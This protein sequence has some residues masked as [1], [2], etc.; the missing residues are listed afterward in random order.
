MSLR[1][2]IAQRSLHA[3]AQLRRAGEVDLERDRRI[4]LDAESTLPLAAG[5]TETSVEIAGVPVRRYSVGDSSNGVVLFLHGGAYVVGGSRVARTYSRLALEGTDII[6]VDYRLAPENPYPAGL[7]DA[8]AVYAALGDAPVVIMGESAGGGLALALAQRLRDEGRRMPLGVVAV[9]PWADLT[10]SSDGFR[11]NA[12]YDSLDKAE[13]DQCA[14]D[15]SGGA[16]LRTP[17]IS[18][19]YG[20]FAGFP[21]TLTVVG[22]RDSL[23]GDAR[24]VHAALAGAGVDSRLL[25]VRGAAHAFLSLPVPEARKALTRISLFVRRV[26]GE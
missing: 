13:L 5:V 17:G 10:Q 23:V 21:T 19:A 2:R 8:T 18:P 22:T 14:R 1:I 6:S 3:G 4:V 25:E 15:Y 11:T 7:D 9:F 24:R 16:D 20:S 12:R 26:L